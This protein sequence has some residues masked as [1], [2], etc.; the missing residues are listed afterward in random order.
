V[1]VIWDLFSLQAINQGTAS[2][3]E[4]HFKSAPS[5]RTMALLRMRY[6]PAEAN[7]LIDQLYL[8]IGRAAFE[9]SRDIGQQSVVAEA[10][11]AV[12]LE[13][14]LLDEAMADPAT[15]DDVLRS[16]GEAVALG[17]FGVPSLVIERPGQPPTRAV[18]GPVISEVPTGE[19]AG[20]Y[21]DHVAWLLERPEF[22][23][24]KRG[25]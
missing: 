22:F 11:A 17:A 5:L 15:L 19:E 2:L 25:R 9:E 16:H 6:E 23:E 1:R 14:A 13:A 4:A 12:G 8:H 3:N 10:L 18:Y 20:L 7:A 21:W 24:L